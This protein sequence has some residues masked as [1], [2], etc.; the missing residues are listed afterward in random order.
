[1]NKSAQRKTICAHMTEKMSHGSKQFYGSQKK[2]AA[3][4]GLS[5]ST[6]KRRMK[7]MET[8]R[9]PPDEQIARTEK[10]FCR[11]GKRLPVYRL[12]SSCQQH[13]EPQE[14]EELK[15][16]TTDLKV[17]RARKRVT[18]PK[19]L[20]GRRRR[21][22]ESAELFPT[23]DLVVRKNGSMT[24][25]NAGDVIAAVIAAHDLPVGPRTRARIGSEA[26]GLLTAGLNPLVVCSACLCALQ[27]SRPHLAESFANE[28]LMAQRGQVWSWSDYRGKLKQLQV[29]GDPGLDR[30]EAAIREYFAK[31]KR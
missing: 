22:V 14:T 16:K 25:F 11:W 26:K 20:H 7:E 21:L 10:V 1:M 28:I 23:A 4:T 9:V 13:S 6:V 27:A 8:A 29:A 30:M 31:G 2:I 15:P 24:A 3:E 17:R 12:P 18:P 5:L 19:D